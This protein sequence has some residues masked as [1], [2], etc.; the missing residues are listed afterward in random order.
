MIKRYWDS[1]ANGMEE[2]DNGAFVTYKDHA[3]LM[4]RVVSTLKYALSVLESI[5]PEMLEILEDSIDE[6]VDFGRIYSLLNDLREDYPPL[7]V[8]NE[9]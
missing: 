4:E 2:I 3:A 9:D 1:Y 7:R 5:P 6:L 8:K